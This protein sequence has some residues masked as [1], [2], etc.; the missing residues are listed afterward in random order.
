M[1]NTQLFQNVFENKIISL[2]LTLSPFLLVL[3][4]LSAYG[5][6]WFERFGT[7]QK[8]TI[9]NKLVSD[10]LWIVVIQLP[11]IMLSD[12]VRYLLG[13]LNP[14]FCFFQVV[15]KA[16]AFTQILCYFDA[17]IVAKYAL[18]F[19]TK[20]PWSINDDFWSRYVSICIYIFSY[21]ANFAR[22]TMI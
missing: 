2:L 9:I 14:H 12:F 15:F 17:M 13:P 5:I 11:L 21:T 10:S 20:N 8:R 22:Y 19:W 7:D 1:N 18:I 4:M 16:S 6:I 3:S